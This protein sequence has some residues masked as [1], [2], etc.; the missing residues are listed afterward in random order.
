[1]TL[2]FAYRF[3]KPERTSAEA[4]PNI[5]MFFGLYDPTNRHF[6]PFPPANCLC[7]QR[8][9]ASNSTCDLLAVGNNKQEAQ[10]NARLMAAELQNRGEEVC[11]QCVAALYSDGI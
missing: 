2:K 9:Y 3:I 8:P 7:G 6:E 1:M 11:G 10:A 5:H 4:S